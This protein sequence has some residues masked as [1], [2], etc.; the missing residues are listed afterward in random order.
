MA[1]HPTA[2]AV[3]SSS[4]AMTI[5]ERAIIIRAIEELGA[6]RVA[7]ILGLEQPTVV[8]LAVPGLRSQRATI[9]VT[10]MALPKLLEAMAA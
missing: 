9:L 8:R 7:E 2:A 10:R 6:R 1:S 3:V 5:Q 4:G